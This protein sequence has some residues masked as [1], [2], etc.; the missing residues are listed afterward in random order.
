MIIMRPALDRCR[1]DDSTGRSLRRRGHSAVERDGTVEV[2]AAAGRRPPVA[3]GIEFRGRVRAVVA[4][5][6]A[7]FAARRFG[8]AA[9]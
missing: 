6:D 7:L 9:R 2:Q 4:D 1:F 3:V 5:D 8:S